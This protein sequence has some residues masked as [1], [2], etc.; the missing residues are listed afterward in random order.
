M[1]RFVSGEL[2]KQGIIIQLFIYLSHAAFCY[3]GF[4]TGKRQKT[5]GGS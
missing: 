4:Q 3:L 5:S 1:V 2:V